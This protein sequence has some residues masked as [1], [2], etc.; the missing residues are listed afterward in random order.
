MEALQWFFG[1]DPHQILPVVHHGDSPQ[2]VKACVKSSSLWIHV[3]EIKLT[4]NMR[5]GPAEVEFAEYLLHI[6]NGTEKLYEKI[7]NQV[8]E[9]WPEYLVNTP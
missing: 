9:V 2:T 1:G 5:V 6:G 4:Q 7:G 3:H 8:I